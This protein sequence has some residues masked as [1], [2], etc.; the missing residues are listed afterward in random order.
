MLLAVGLAVAAI[1]ARAG[2]SS[3]REPEIVLSCGLLGLLA[4]F[5]RRI[6]KGAGF[7]AFFA[8]VAVVHV[9]LLWV[10]FDLCFP[11]AEPFSLWVT[12]VLAGEAYLVQR[13]ANVFRAKGIAL[14]KENRQRSP[15]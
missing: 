12:L 6:W 2:V 8:M 3:R 9:L 11:R 1:A 4:V 13:T 10:L 7:W 15:L 14:Q 5:R